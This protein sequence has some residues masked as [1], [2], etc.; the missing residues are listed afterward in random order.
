MARWEEDERRRIELLSAFDGSEKDVSAGH[1]TDYSNDT[2]P[3]L[4]DELK[5][6]ARAGLTSDRRS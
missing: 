3:H 5:R 2:L 1:Y 6:E 4:A